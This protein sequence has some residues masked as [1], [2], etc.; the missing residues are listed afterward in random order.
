MKVTR[1]L[2]AALIL[3]LAYGNVALTQKPGTKK[4][5]ASKPGTRPSTRRFQRPGRGKRP[6]IIR[7]NVKKLLVG[8]WKLSKAFYPGAPRN[9]HAAGYVVFTNT[10]ASFHI[11]LKEKTAEPVFQSGFWRYSIIGN[12]ILF[13]SLLDLKSDPTGKIYLSGGKAITRVFQVGPGFLR[14]FRQRGAYLDFVKID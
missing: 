12:R 14:L 7:P 2:L 1:I 4:A 10:Y 3:A 5:P 13:Q 8:A 9:L 11:I 6:H